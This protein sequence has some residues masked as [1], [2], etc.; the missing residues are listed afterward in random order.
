[1]D[2]KGFRVAWPL[3]SIAAMKRGKIFVVRAPT[4]E[5]WDR[6]AET[7]AMVG[8]SHFQKNGHEYNSAKEELSRIQLRCQAA[9][10][11]CGSRPVLIIAF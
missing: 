8:G 7:S 11:S 3:S 6:P 5:E 4:R 2:I 10:G 1:M 9:A